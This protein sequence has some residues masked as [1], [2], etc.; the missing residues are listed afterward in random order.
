MPKGRGLPAAEL[1]GLMSE[2]VI[3]IHP[4]IHD[5]F[6]IR[7]FIAPLELRGLLDAI[8]IVVSQRTGPG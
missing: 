1:A 3:P 2:Q 5:V 8:L 6:L 4:S 7:T